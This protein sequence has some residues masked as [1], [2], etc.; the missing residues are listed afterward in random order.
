MKEVVKLTGTQGLVIGIFI[1]GL[2]AFLSF[3]ISEKIRDNTKKSK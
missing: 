3:Y 2:I 1:G